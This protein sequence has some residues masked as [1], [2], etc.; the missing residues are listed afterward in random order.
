MRWYNRPMAIWPTLFYLILLGGLALYALHLTILLLLYFHHHH[1]PPD[2]PPSFPEARLP[3]VTVQLPVRNE[4]ALAVRSLEALAALDWPRDRLQLQVLDDSDDGTTALLQEA[5][6]RLRDKGI[7]VTLHHRER[8]CGF[9][10]GALAAVMPRVRGELIALFDAD[11]VPPRDFLRRTVPYLIRDARL[12][13]VQSRW[14]HRNAEQNLITRAQAMLLDAHFAIEQVARHRSGLLINFNGTAGIWRKVALLDAGGWQADTLTE[15]LDLSYRAQVLGW[16]TLYLEG[17]TASATLPPTLVAFQQQQYRWAKG[18]AQVLRKLAGPLLRSPQ[19]SVRQKMMALC[20]LSGYLT[21]L[22][23]LLLMVMTGP[24]LLCGGEPP[25]MLMTFLGGLLAIPPLL[26]F[27]AQIE[28]YRDWPRRLLIYPLVMLIG[29]G[30][31]W[32]NA[33]AW[34]DGFLH[35]GGEF[36]RTLKERSVIP[37]SRRSL[38]LLAGEALL[39]SYLLF[40]AGEAYRLRAYGWFQLALFYAAG[41]AMMVGVKLWE[42]WRP[43]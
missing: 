15:D 20:H 13:F 10:A 9:K 34:L 22:L 29:V 11:F 5:V 28:L 27:A 16:R 19:L 40:V 1:D 39:M 7:E 6:V 33:I 42:M 8:P 35:R 3:C 23:L 14:K 21:Q 25:P 2:P 32:S 18:S 17:V 12:A 30:L 24:M 4:G 38:Y 26:Y 41:M 37:F 31:A 36:V 43:E